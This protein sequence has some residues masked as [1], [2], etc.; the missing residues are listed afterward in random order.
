MYT[1]PK[2]GLARIAPI[3]TSIMCA[4]VAIATQISLLGSQH[5]D[6]WLEIAGFQSVAFI[7]CIVILSK[8]ANKHIREIEEYMNKDEV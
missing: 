6:K 5:E 7:A 4:G 1:Y 8:L 2:Y 3:T